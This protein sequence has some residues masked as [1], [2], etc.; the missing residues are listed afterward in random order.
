MRSMPALQ[1]KGATAT[2]PKPKRDET[3]ALHVPFAVK[4]DSL[5][6][7]ARTFTGLASTWDLDLG[8]D[9]ILK[10]AF[11]KTL[12]DWRRSKSVLPLLDSHSAY[13]TVRAVV[14]KMVDAKETDGGLEATFE[15]IEGPDGDEIWRRIKGGYVTGLSIGYRAVKIDMP[16][17]E[18]QLAGVW[19]YLKEVALREVS[20]VVW[21]MNQG[22]RI[23]AGS[24][25]A[26]AAD[27][28]AL[29]E[30]AAGRDLTENEKAE[31]VDLQQKIAA[32]LLGDEAPAPQDTPPAEPSRD[33]PPAEKAGLAPEDPVRVAAE[34]Q[35]RAARLRALG[36]HARV[37]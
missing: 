11:R 16:S 35:L 5:D 9:V 31:L 29:E 18:E 22:A 10:G 17:E 7:S 37:A 4:A 1:T 25:K 21:P 15:V 14:G 28:A 33:A 27:I 26:L 34:E 24:M 36:T 6:D 32:L 8:G 13:G 3:K 30:T 23:D 2:A 12:A 20:V 19:R